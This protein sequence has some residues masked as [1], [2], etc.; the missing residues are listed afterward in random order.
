MT[1]M[2]LLGSSLLSLNQNQGDDGNGGDDDQQQQSL[3]LP[4]FV[5]ILKDEEYTTESV[6]NIQAL[7]G[8][9]T[10]RG[11]LVV[12]STASSGDSDDGQQQQYTNPAPPS[13]RGEDTPSANLT[14]D[15]DYEWNTFGNS[16]ILEDMWGIPTGYVPDVNTASYLL[17]TAL[18][19]FNSLT[20]NANSNSA[21]SLEG[22]P[23]SAEFNYYMG[24][25]EMDTA[26]CLSWKDS[27]EKWRPKCLPLG[28]NSVWALAGSPLSSPYQPENEDDERRNTQ[29]RRHLEQS[30]EERPIILVAS[31]MDATSMFH[32]LSPG[33]N[34][35]ASNILTVLLAAKL[36]GES[37]SDDELD[38]FPAQIGFALFAGETYGYLGSRA[39]FTDIAGFECESDD[40]IVPNNA[41]KS[42]AGEEIKMACLNPLRQELDFAAL[43]GIQSM[44]AVDQVGLLA[45]EDT[46][47]VHSNGNYYNSDTLTDLFTGMS[48]DDWTIEEGSAGAIPPSPL[49]TFGKGVVLTGYDDS[50]VD[51][52]YSSHLDSTMTHSMNLKSIAKAATIVARVALGAAYAG[53]DPDDDVDP[54]DYAENAIQELEYDDESLVELA[55]CFFTNGNC[56]ALLNYGKKEEA[57]TQEE[58][59]VDLGVGQYLG[60]PPNYYPDVYNSQTG[61]AFVYLD[62]KSYGAYNGDKE[63]GKNKNDVF[64]IKPSLLEMAIHGLMD[65][66]LGRGSLDTDGN[67]SRDNLKSCKSTSDCSKVS[68]CSAS[69]DSTVCSGS[70]SCVCSRSHY[71]VALDTAL[72]PSPNNSTGY[73]IVSDDD[74]GASAMYSE[75]YWDNL[76]GIHVYRK[77]GSAGNWAFGLGIAVALVWIGGTFFLRKKLTKEKLY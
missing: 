3:S 19:Q 36:I 23:V 73:F 49:S 65:D 34:S 61:Q 64:L 27:D 38:G 40:L 43:T 44:I 74:D 42:Q 4:E 72:R 67:S 21:V 6:Q 69:Y 17:S 51:E 13:P 15:N 39:F 26:T 14:P 37:V 2:I 58:T 32:E 52:Y 45:Q 24:P 54:I 71:H 9:G 30:E 57:N 77:G 31:N 20:I 47:Y 75:P 55:D 18:K 46:F 29:R 59:G 70:G 5:V 16:L 60:S 33:A 28:G 41:K 35:A 63:Y 50:F 76:V 53:D 7:D 68:Y 8:D 66:Y 1:G 12:N 25:Q 62:G 11:I 48:S 22:A 10:L 56:K